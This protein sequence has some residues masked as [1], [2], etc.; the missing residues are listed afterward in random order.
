MRLMPLSAGETFAGFRIVRLLGSGGMGEV[1]R[2]FDTDT[3]RIVAIKVL[4][5]NFSDNE[6]FKRRFRREAHAARRDAAARRSG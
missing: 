3:D 2:A 6:D 5:A 1:W 4:P